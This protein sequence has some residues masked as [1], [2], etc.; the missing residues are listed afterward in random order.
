MSEVPIPTEEATSTHGISTKHGRMPNGELRFRLVSRD[1]ND[2]IRTV[3]SQTSGWQKAHFH[4]S[5]RETYI[6]ER[7][8][9]ALAEKNNA[10]MSLTIYRPND[11][12]TTTPNVVHNVYLPSQAV[13]HTVKHGAA[14][15]GDWTE[16]AAFTE[17]TS[18]LTEST[19]LSWEPPAAPVLDLRF[20]AYIALYNNLDNLI[21]RIP[22]F[23]AAGAAIAIGFAGSVLSKDTVPNIPPIL[24]ASLFFFIGLLFFLSAFSMARIREHHT[25][26]GNFLR[27]MEPSGYFHMRQTTVQRRWPPSATKVFRWVYA[28]LCVLFFALT[29]VAL[30]RFQWLEWLLQWKPSG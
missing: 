12:V 23:L 27:D 29:V 10:G 22:G 8:W 25:A 7:G 28:G 26:A 20:D 18:Q 16:D 3:A 5:L 14:G 19:I 11:V 4:R 17:A 15:A 1:G 9:M 30:V 24:I 6:V 13:I 2:Y 21:W